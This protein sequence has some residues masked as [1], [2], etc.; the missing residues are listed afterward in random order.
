MARLPEDR[1]LPKTDAETLRREVVA[2]EWFHRIDLGH[3]VVTPGPDDS[4]AKLAT[5]DLPERLDGWSVADIGA[6]DGFFSFEAERRGAERVVAFDSYMWQ[7][8]G[9]DGFDLARR[10][11]GSDVEPVEAE[12]VDL[13]PEHGSFDLTL[14]LGVLY[15]MRHPLLALERVASITENMLVLE[16]HVDFLGTRRPAGAFYPGAALMNDPTNWWGLNPPAIEAMLRE[17]GFSRVR[18]IS[19]TPLRQRL[20]DGTRLRLR[21]QA[22]FLEGTR[23]GRAVFHAFKDA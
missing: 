18:T 8:R 10:V 9:R 3:G 5:L 4:P 13:S 6:L 22:R 14:F 17:V 20:W 7:V 21:N 19:V 11:L 2:I 16:S 15:H 1:Q 23:Q 12:V